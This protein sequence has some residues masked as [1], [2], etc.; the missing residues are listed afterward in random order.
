MPVAVRIFGDPYRAGEPF[1]PTNELRRLDY[2]PTLRN[3][4]GIFMRPA[5]H[6]DA[7]P[8][9]HLLQLERRHRLS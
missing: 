5:H 4:K 8:A 6:S 7:A 3:L 2:A 1:F 9:L